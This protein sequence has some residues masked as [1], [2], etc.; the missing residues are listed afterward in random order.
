MTCKLLSF[1]GES[2]GPFYKFNYPSYSVLTFYICVLG[3][4]YSRVGS[5]HKSSQCSDG[6]DEDSAS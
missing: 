2:L 1:F 5:R 4:S 3:M 6:W